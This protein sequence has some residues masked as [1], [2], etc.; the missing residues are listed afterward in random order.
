MVVE[1]YDPGLL[2]AAAGDIEAMVASAG[3]GFRPGF[4]QRYTLAYLLQ[5]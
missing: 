2:D 3:L 4:R 1:A 5:E